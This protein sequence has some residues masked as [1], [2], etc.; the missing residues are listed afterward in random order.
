MTNGLH[1]LTGDATLPQGDGPKIIVHICN[2]IGAWGAGFVLA[3]SRRYPEPETEYRHWYAGREQN[4]FV[5]GAVQ[6]VSVGPDIWTANLIGQ[7]GIRRKNGDP[8]VRYDAIR[9]G[10]SKV[11][12]F[13]IEVGATI[14]MPRIGAGLAGGDWNIIAEILTE[15]V[16]ARGVSVNVYDLPLSAKP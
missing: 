11:A 4:D 10:L 14:H 1:Y 2:D 5:L 15:E 3:L 8:P 7:H 13:A 6:F 16:I 9:A 12:A